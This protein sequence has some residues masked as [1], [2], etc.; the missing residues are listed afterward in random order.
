MK[1]VSEIIF[2]RCGCR[3]SAS[4][5]QWGRSC[6]LLVDP[7]HGRWYYSVQAAAGTGRRARIRRG[8]YASF[9][10]AARARDAFLDLADA[11][12][13]GRSWTVKRWLE[14][15]LD[16]ARL[17][18]RPS[19]LRSYREHIRNHLVPNLGHL[20][21][22][23]LRTSHL[24]AA[25]RVIAEYR[26]RSGRPLATSTIARIR[27]TLR[28][29]L[30]EA[31]RQGLISKSPISR[32]RLPKPYRV[33]PVVWTPTRELA[34]QE[35]GQRPSVAVWSRRHLAE[36][37]AFVK[38]DPLFELWWL[39]SLS[40]LRR[41]EV[42]ALRWT[43]IDLD[44]ATLTVREQIVVV[45]GRDIVGPPK[46]ASS[47]RTIALDASTVRLPRRARPFFSTRRAT[48]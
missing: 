44:D 29:A 39:V 36:F 35:T 7:S 19:T 5:K 34:W 47:C 28:S 30:S 45:D 26:T 27:A 42:A 16:A 43:D 13:V 41:G 17:H 15:W 8:G 32:L 2:R 20:R 14:H 18:L 11:A 6:P 9:D 31:V 33:R 24:Q 37:L 22:A 3:D 10:E 48:G 40:G 4:S 12:A 46:S 21:L 1:Q 25:F 23:E 38:N